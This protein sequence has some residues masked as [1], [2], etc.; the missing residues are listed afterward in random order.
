MVVCPITATGAA[1]TSEAGST[2][3]LRWNFTQTRS[4]QQ[5]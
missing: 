2:T 1:T 3:H 4:T 5:V